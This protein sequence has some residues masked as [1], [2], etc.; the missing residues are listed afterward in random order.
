M[1]IWLFVTVIA[2]SGCASAQ[3]EANAQRPDPLYK[4]GQSISDSRLCAC[5]ECF[6]ASCCTGDPG[7]EDQFAN[8]EA[9]NGEA[10]NGEAANGE[11]ANGEVALGMSLAVC[12]RCARR[13][14][15]VRG[16]ESCAARAPEACCPGSIQGLS[17]SAESTRA[18]NAM[19]VARCA[20]K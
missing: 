12:G 8:G 2:F 4:P 20:A 15:T 17:A 7:V 9:A 5:T 11:A 13:V 6:K 14:W 1:F 16:A 18:E 10:A 3:T 19:R